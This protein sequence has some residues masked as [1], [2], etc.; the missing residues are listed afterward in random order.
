MGHLACQITFKHF[1]HAVPAFGIGKQILFAVAQA[2]VNVAT[3]TRISGIPLGHEAGHDA[4][5]RANFFGACFEQNGTVGLCEGIAESNGRFINA[6]P[7]FCVQAFNGDAKLQ[8]LVLNGIEELAILVHA[9]QGVTEHARCEGGG[10]DA[11]F[12]FP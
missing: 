9:Q 10:A 5:A 1:T 3:A 12:T 11:F 6:W 2:L 7:R 8:H 4:K